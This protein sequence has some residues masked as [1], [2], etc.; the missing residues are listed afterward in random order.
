MQSLIL[1]RTKTYSSIFG[2]AMA[3][4]L[5]VV[6]VTGVAPVASASGAAQ[7]T[8]GDAVYFESTFGGSSDIWSVVPGQRP[9]R[10]A[11]S[12]KGT[13]DQQPTIS[14]DGRWL[15]FSSNRGGDFEIY[16]VDLKAGSK[17]KPLSVTTNTSADT[18]PAWSPD[19][20]SITYVTNRYNVSEIM[21]I[22]AAGCKRRSKNCDTRITSNKF[23]DIDP[24]WSPDGQTIVF[25][26][27]RSRD[28]GFQIYTMTTQGKSATRTTNVAANSTDPTWS[29]DGGSIAFVS[30]RRAS[31]DRTT[32]IYTML[33][34]GNS[35]KKITSGS[36]NDKS[37]VWSPDGKS[38]TFASVGRRSSTVNSVAATGGKITQLMTSRAPLSSVTWGESI[39][40]TV[41]AIPRRPAATPT[42]KPSPTATATVIPVKPTATRVPPTATPVPPK[43]TL[44]PTPTTVV[45]SGEG[46]FASGPFGTSPEIAVLS[47]LIGAAIESFDGIF[48]GTVSRSSIAPDSICNFSGAYGSQYSPTSFRSL[49]SKYGSMFG[50]QSAYDMGAPDPPQLIINGNSVARLSSSLALSHTVDPDEL[51]RF[52]GCSR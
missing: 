8:S 21:V 36:S 7:A 42:P 18:S 48:L 16:V 3:L 38:V 49:G 37:P 30:M 39:S 29:P 14:P 12:S 51:L 28:P 24:A 35:Q 23:Q 31:R 11:F 4:V 20:K 32:A 26:S 10:A 27:K 22:P 2:I 1:R 50:D 17:A 19:G 9:Q 6:A 45:S 52:F 44:V 43:P 46:T 40:S 15:A 13:N 33:A 25:S 5:A 34:N 47:T 41:V